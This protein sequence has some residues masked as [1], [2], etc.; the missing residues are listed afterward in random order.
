[1]VF[2][3]QLQVKGG[4]QRVQNILFFVIK[5]LQNYVNGKVEGGGGTGNCISAI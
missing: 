2:N 3:I 1:L 4:E 5:H